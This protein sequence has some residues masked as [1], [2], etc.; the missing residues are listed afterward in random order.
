MAW[1]IAS[2]ITS[3]FVGY[4][5][6]IPSALAWGTDGIYTSVIVKNI[7][8]TPMIEEIKIEQGSGLTSTQVLINDGDEVNFTVEDDRNVTWPLAGQTVTLIN[9]Q[10]NGSAGTSELFQVIHNNYSVARKQNGE[11]TINAKKY[12]L[13]TP[14]NM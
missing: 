14:A 10:P 3:N 1:P 12:S 7:T 2:N 8:S 4:K 11:R 9:P 13:V 5:G 6:P